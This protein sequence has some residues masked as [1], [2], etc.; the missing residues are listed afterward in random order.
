MPLMTPTQ[1]LAVLQLCSV[2]VGLQVLE[3]LGDGLLTHF[4]PY[5][6]QK[7]KPSKAF[8]LSSPEQRQLL[9]VGPLPKMIN[10][11]LRCA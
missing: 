11:K 4:Y 6:T 7:P 8:Y 2:T 10:I 1:G 9:R 3:T 5:L